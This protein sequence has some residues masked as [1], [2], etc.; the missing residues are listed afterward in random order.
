M[1]VDETYEGWKPLTLA[2]S[3]FDESFVDWCEIELMYEQYLHT[4]LA[5][6]NQDCRELSRG[7][8]RPA[9]L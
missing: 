9:P 3:L 5:Y 7:L 4:F 6:F 1:T 8:V 2:C